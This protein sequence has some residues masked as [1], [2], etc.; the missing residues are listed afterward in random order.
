MAEFDLEQARSALI[1]GSD[2]NGPS[3]PLRIFS[4]VDGCVLK[5]FEENARPVPAGA[6]LMEAE[7]LSGLAEGELVILHPPDKVGDGA[8]VVLK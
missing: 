5:V 4:P 2:Q 3:G 8:R 7:V 1:Q 6:P